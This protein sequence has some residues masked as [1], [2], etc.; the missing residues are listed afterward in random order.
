MGAFGCSEGT[1]DTDGS[2]TAGEVTAADSTDESSAGDA[3][4]AID[5][6]DAA[7][8]TDESASTDATDMTD[9]PE[10]WEPPPV[11]PESEP[12][13]VL[14][15]TIMVAPRPA[16]SDP[17]AALLDTWSVELPITGLQ[18]ELYWG[19]KQVVD[20]AFEIPGN[21]AVWYAAFEV[22]MEADARASVQLDRVS[23][24]WVNGIRQPGDP[25]GAGIHRVPVRLK[26]GKNL[27][28]AV[29]SNRG[30]KPNIR[31]WEHVH[32]VAFV[33]SDRT[34]PHLEPSWSHGHYLGLPVLNL[35]DD[36]LQDVRLTVVE[37]EHFEP[38]ERVLDVWPA[39]ASV[40]LGFELKPV[41]I[42]TGDEIPV[43]LRVA[44]PGL[45][46]SYEWSG[47]VQSASAEPGT[48]K[49][50]T[51]ISSIDR[52]VQYYAV[53]EPSEDTEA[54]DSLVLTLHGAS[55]Q[56][57]GQADAYSAKPDIW[58]VAPTN[59]RPFGF[60][61]EAFGRLDGLEVLAQA[62]ASLPT[63]ENHVYLTGHSM[64]G[65]GSW[66]LGLLFPGR[67]AVVGPSAGWTSF[68][69]Y[70]GG[71]FPQGIMGYASLSSQTKRYANNL[72]QRG[73]YILHGTADDNVPVSHAR[74]MKALMEPIAEVFGYHEEEG[75]GHWWNVDP[76]P[77]ADCVDWPP[78]FE[79]F[80][81]R[82]F[83]PHELE[84]SFISPTPGVS[85]THSYLTIR[86]KGDESIPCSVTSSSDGT[87]V[88][89]TQE[90]V[91]AIE[92]DGAILAAKG[93]TEVTALGATKPVVAE[94]MSF[95]ATTKKRPDAYGPFSQAFHQPFC[96]VWED[97]GPPRYQHI[98]SE[99]LSSWNI[100]GN[101]TGCALPLS[102][103][104]E[105]LADSYQ[106]IYLGVAPENIPEFPAELNI[107]WDEVTISVDGMSYG[108]GALMMVFPHRGR[109]AAVMTTTRTHEYLLDGMGPFSS[110]FWFPDFVVYGFDGLFAAGFFDEN[111][112]FDPSATIAA[113]S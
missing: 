73:V 24:I 48:T 54:P 111:W 66:Q 42:P 58:H 59:R 7:D 39:Y 104:T 61:W 21:A 71:P 6:T 37:S 93:I 79:M 78:L 25:Y 19:E 51:F 82:T 69:E 40:Q 28:Y 88:T 91:V 62:Q 90:N 27:I 100:I 106:P 8:S 107:S 67:F 108:P 75:A 94:V 15:D 64:G 31:I 95:G 52:S 4:D 109:L 87:T 12:V 50:R 33:P 105:Q 13:E 53:R 86:A 103:F 3:T 77:G 84:F 97:S 34:W 14:F 38:T 113:G 36:S 81:S 80:A 11:A 112:A 2:D 101:G 22:E 70:N 98:A 10:P 41:N 16:D 110:R 1:G 18:Y 102:K 74:V 60:D 76:A 68:D 32:E 83:D 46:Y 20:G 96:F 55:V 29:G 85:A 35:T 43:T 56:A 57:K 26:A 45:E 49:R 9:D 5:T 99:L 17:L 23:A 65:H 47:T 92:V 44:A 89:I 63:S 30:S 72:E